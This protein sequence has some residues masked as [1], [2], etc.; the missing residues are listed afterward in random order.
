MG[1]KFGYASKNNGWLRLEN[2]RIPRENLF[3]KFTKVDN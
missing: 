3:M 1:P 2:V